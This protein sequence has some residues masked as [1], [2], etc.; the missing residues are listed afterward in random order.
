MSKRSAAVV[1]LENQLRD[2]LSPSEGLTE[3]RWVGR[4]VDL[5][6]ETA[7]IDGRTFLLR[8]ILNTPQTERA[9]FS[10]FIQLDG[11]DILGAWINDH[12]SN[13]TQAD[14][15][16]INS[17]LSCLNKLSMTMEILEKSGIGKTVNNLCKINDPSLQAKAKSI[18][19]KWKKL[20]TNPEEERKPITNV[21]KPKVK[22]VR[23]PLPKR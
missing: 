1:E 10:R 15:E 2:M 23:V 12:K 16:V 11:V 21:K 8:V 17:A 9:T 3:A 22:E 5:M 7:N 6:K 20:V 18:V 13:T 4:L 14:R 19:S